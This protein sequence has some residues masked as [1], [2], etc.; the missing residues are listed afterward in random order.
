MGQA[1]SKAVKP[2]RLPRT[3]DKIV[4]QTPG[5]LATREQMLHEDAETATDNATATHTA[6]ATHPVTATHPATAQN[7]N[8]TSDAQLHDNLKYFLNPRE[9]QP[10]VPL[11]SPSDNPN[12]QALRNRHFTSTN[13][14]SGGEVAQMLR[15]LRAIRPQSQG[16]G[17]MSTKYALDRQ[18]VL[19]LDKFLDPVQ[20]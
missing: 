3:V 16:I 9:L 19:A 14:A 20:K 4:G 18:T 11:K 8:Q 10:P 5:K 17:H 12:I 7:K 1:G 6:T 15:E 2:M 13:R